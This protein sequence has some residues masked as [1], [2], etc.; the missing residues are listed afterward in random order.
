MIVL[1]SESLLMRATATDGRI[2]R[3]RMLS[4][5]GVRLNARKRTFLVA[6]SVRGQQF[7][8]M[9]GYW[10][11]MS[12]E[13][14]RSKAMEVLRKCRNGE[15]PSRRVPQDLPTLREAYGAYCSTKGIKASSQRRYESFY[16][17]HFGAWLDQ[18]VDI[19]YNN[20]NAQVTSLDDGSS[21]GK[22]LKA[23]MVVS[24]EGSPV[25]AATTSGGTA[26]AT[27]YR[28]VC[29]SEW[30]GPVSNIN[31]A[32]SSFDILGLTVDVVDSTVFEGLDT[33]TQLSELSDT[34]YV[35]VHGEVNPA[36]G[37]L[38]ASHI[39]VSTTSPA[40]FK[41]SGIVRNMNT[42]LQSFSVGSNTQLS[43]QIYWNASTSTPVRWANGDFVRVMMTASL[44]PSLTA[45]RIRLLTS[46]FTQLGSEN[47]QAAVV[48]GLISTF[49]SAARFIVNGLTV[50]ARNAE[51]RGGDLALGVRVVIQGSISQGVLIARQIETPNGRT[52][53]EFHGIVSE[54]NLTAQ[55]F[56]LRGLK[57]E[58]TNETNVQGVVLANG[59]RIELKANR[60]PSK[61]VVTQ[62]RAED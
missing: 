44:T 17:T 47:E 34:H 2:L 43:N 51:V 1:I 28:I 18:P 4:G 25:V 38:Q 32:A 56:K 41:L 27:A 9:L 52:E 11:L 23:G 8:M 57:F 46:P 59:A 15:R 58:Y 49:D 5:F 29:G 20:D 62:I 48:Q 14:A 55:T 37:H 31:V 42:D 54:L 10:P 19:R 3:D 24:I 53:F 61:W 22:E 35:E 16:R 36:T 33:V 13:E 40:Y 30:Q 21:F 45:T 50:D 6:T 26:T 12:V 60:S 39:E 7:R